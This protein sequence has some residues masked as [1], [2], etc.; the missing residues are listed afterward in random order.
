MAGQIAVALII[1]KQDNHIGPILFHEKTVF[2][3]VRIRSDISAPFKI[4]F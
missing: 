3:T 2:S 1:G 4:S